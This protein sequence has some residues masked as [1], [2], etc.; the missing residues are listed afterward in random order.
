MGLN[1]RGKEMENSEKNR[2]K[3]FACS[4]FRRY[5]TKGDYCFN[6]TEYGFCIRKHEMKVK[7]DTCEEW[8]R[9]SRTR[10]TDKDKAMK[11]LSETLWEIASIRQILQ[12]AQKEEQKK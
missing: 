11:V 9:N 1:W 7:H 12:E 4:R 3:C 2:K 10:Y 6:R 5:Y 8:D